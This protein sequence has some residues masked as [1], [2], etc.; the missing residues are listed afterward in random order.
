[1]L[2]VSI[3]FYLRCH[4]FPRLLGCC[5]E[6]IVTSAENDPNKCFQFNS[7]PVIKASTYVSVHLGDFYLTIF[8]FSIFQN[9][10]VRKFGKTLLQQRIHN[11]GIC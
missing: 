1:M 10:S 3:I 6:A 5:M 7:I 4:N 9:R 11:K 2:Q 8:A